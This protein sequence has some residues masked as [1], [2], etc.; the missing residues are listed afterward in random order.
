MARYKHTDTEYGQGIFLSVNL[1]KQL[2][3]GTFEYML[4]DLVGN[5]ID[6]SMF[7]KNYKNDNNGASSGES[8]SGYRAVTP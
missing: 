5:T 1:K 7:D 3:P 4:N 6:V 8:S 2:L